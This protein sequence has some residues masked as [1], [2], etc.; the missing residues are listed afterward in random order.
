MILGYDHGVGTFDI[1]KLII[2]G[3][4]MAKIKNHYEVP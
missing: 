3:F 4:K 2:I 1:T